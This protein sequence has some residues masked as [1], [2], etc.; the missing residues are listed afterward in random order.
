MLTKADKTLVRAATALNVTGAMSWARLRVSVDQYPVLLTAAGDAYLTQ[1]AEMQPDGAQFVVMRWYLR[2]LMRRCALEGAERVLP[3]LSQASPPL[4]LNWFL[5]FSD[6]QFTARKA[7]E[8]VPHLMREQSVAELERMIEIAARIDDPRAVGW[9]YLPWLLR[10]CREHGVDAALPKKVFDPVA[11]VRRLR[12]EI[13]ALLWES[14]QALVAFLPAGTPE[15]IG[16]RFLR[17]LSDPDHIPG[18]LESLGRVNDKFLALISDPSFQREDAGVQAGVMCVPAMQV[19][20]L[21]ETKASHA[22]NLRIAASLGDRA[23]GRPGGP[24]PR[25]RLADARLRDQQPGRNAGRAS[26]QDRAPGGHRRGR[27]GGGRRG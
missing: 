18:T 27:R 20:M 15:G 2:D 24:A 1:V 8:K 6:S 11:G 25:S 13:K 19:S 3:P 26:H 16:D 12:R 10:A 17:L 9:R 23:T 5:R 14:Q 21:G 22:D 4:R 7:L